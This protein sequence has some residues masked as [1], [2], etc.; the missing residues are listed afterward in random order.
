M[1]VKFNK[2]VKDGGKVTTILIGKKKYQHLCAIG[3]KQ[4]KGEVKT[5]KQSK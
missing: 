2:C 3:G 5:R 1:G 4:Y